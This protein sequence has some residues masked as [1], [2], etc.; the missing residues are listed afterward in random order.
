MLAEIYKTRKGPSPPVAFERYWLT[1]AETKEKG[2]MSKQKKRGKNRKHNNYELETKKG[3]E[4]K[5][6]E[7]TNA[8]NIETRKSGHRRNNN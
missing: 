6:N 2:Q 7:N 8:R 1:G 3:R 4:P 5:R